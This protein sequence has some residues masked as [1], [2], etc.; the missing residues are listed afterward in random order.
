MCMRD[1]SFTIYCIHTS[2]FSNQKPTLLTPQII[3]VHASDLDTGNNAR[4]T[5]RI[6]G[7]GRR[8]ASNT[9]SNSNSTTSTSVGA[10]H[11]TLADDAAATLR[12]KAT[13]TTAKKTTSST[14]NHEYEQADSVVDEAVAALFGIFPNNGFIYLRASLDRETRDRYDIT[15]EASDNGTPAASAITRV[16]VSVLDANDNDPVFGRES[17]LFAVEENLRRGAIIGTV[18]ATDA[19]VEANAVIRYSLIPSNT[20][21][22]V[23]PVTGK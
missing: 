2:P 6:V 10:F 9:D 13:K 8:L 17:Y 7:R 1:F 14:A 16:V 21:F 18:A 5:Y 15:V 12:T 22:Q 4:I 11:S 23:N 3:Q 20:S 19:D